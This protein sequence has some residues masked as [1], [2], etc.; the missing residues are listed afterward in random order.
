MGNLSGILS[1][2]TRSLSA[3]EQALAV[4]QTNISNIATPHYARA[5]A[6]LSPVVLP[7]QSMRAR[8]RASM[9]SP[10]R[11]CATAFSSCRC[12]ARA[13]RPLCSTRPRAFSTRSR[14][15]FRSTPKA[16]SAKAST[17]S[18]P[19]FRRCR[20]TRPTSTCA[21]RCCAPRAK[22]RR[23]FTAPTQTCRR[24]AGNW[25]A[26]RLS[27]V[28]TINTLLDR[29]GAPGRQSLQRQRRDQP[30]ERNAADAGL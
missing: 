15:A 14:W 13:S 25:K 24:A 1:S 16:P 7:R 3:F 10:P 8:P 29:G 23:R 9:S 5:R 27:T 28:G 20:S 22:W 4:V 21:P 18:S 17:T 12:S 30:L 11:N 2:A 19:P 6:V 26:R